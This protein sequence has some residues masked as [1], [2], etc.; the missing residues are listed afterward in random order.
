[1]NGNTSTSDNHGSDVLISALAFL[2]TSAAMI[3]ALKRIPTTSATTTTGMKSLPKDVVKYS[4]VPKGDKKFTATTIPKGLLKAH[5]TKKGTWGVINVTKG[6]LRYQIN[7]PSLAVHVLSSTQRGIIEPQIR[8]E[9]KA[10]TDD[11]EFVVEFYRLPNT[12][13]VDEK[14]EGL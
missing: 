2:T 8:H 13:P 3:V 7:E 10:L 5:N 6:Q 1:M 9:V 11:L 14:R 12:G 4:Q